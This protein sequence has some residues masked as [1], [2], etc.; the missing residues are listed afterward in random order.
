MDIED[1]TGEGLEV[2]NIL[3]ETEEGVSLLYSGRNLA[4]LYPIVL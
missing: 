4:E 1:T 2:R 3:L